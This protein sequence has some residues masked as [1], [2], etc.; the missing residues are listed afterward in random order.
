MAAAAAAVAEGERKQKE[1]TLA[2]HSLHA[3]GTDCI[4]GSQSK[5]FPKS[6]IPLSLFYRQ[7]LQ[8]SVAHPRSHSSWL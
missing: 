6:Q 4:T 1:P 3:V 8:Q 7:E 5:T 2:E